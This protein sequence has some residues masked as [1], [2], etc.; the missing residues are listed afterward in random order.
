MR[1]IRFQVS[2]INFSEEKKSPKRIGSFR[3]IKLIPS[4]RLSY[5]VKPSASTRNEY[6]GAW[7][8]THLCIFSLGVEGECCIPTGGHYRKVNSGW[9]FPA[10][11]ECQRESRLFIEVEVFDIKLSPQPWSVRS[12]HIRVRFFRSR[13]E[14]TC[15]PHVAFELPGLF[16]QFFDTLRYLPVNSPC[17]PSKTIGRTGV[18]IR[19]FDQFVGLAR[20]AKSNYELAYGDDEKSNTRQRLNPLME[21]YFLYQNPSPNS[22]ATRLS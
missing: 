14:P 13:G 8:S 15:L 7:F 17:A 19:G 18:L 10:I 16:V 6:R 9:S 22:F 5:S 4:Y 11:R 21:G 2:V 1:L 3:T 12:D 20:S